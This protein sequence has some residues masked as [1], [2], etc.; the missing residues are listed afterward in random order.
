MALSSAVI[1]GKS[2][3]SLV[4][5]TPSMVIRRPFTTT[6]SFATSTKRFTSWK[7]SARLK[8]S[9]T[10]SMSSG[11]VSRPA[12][13]PPPAVAVAPG[14]AAPPPT[15]ARRRSRSR[16]GCRGLTPTARRRR[17]AGRRSGR[18]RWRSRRRHLERSAR[19]RRRRRSVPCRTTSHPWSAPALPACSRAR[20]WR[21]VKRM[22]VPSAASSSWTIRLGMS[23][24][25]GIAFPSRTI[26]P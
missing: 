12:G 23:T 24:P 22:L 8:K 18:P 11:T 6:F 25:D 14:V 5:F 3:G 19:T 15:G 21:C 9:P 20:P 1:R 13:A 4:N 7:K 16:S 10:N 17:C 2:C 26:S